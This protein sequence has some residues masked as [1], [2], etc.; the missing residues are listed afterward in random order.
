MKTVEVISIF[1]CMFLV[2]WTAGDG[3]PQW[4]PQGRFGKRFSNAEFISALR[5]APVEHEQTEPL[6][7]DDTGLSMDAGELE[8]LYNMLPA[9]S[10]KSKQTMLL[11]F[12]RAVSYSRTCSKTS[13][14]GVFKCF[15][16][17]WADRSLM[18]MHKD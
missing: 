7:L 14:L 16:K 9:N 15:R 4:R 12:P 11:P 1:L 5:T 13:F 3:A 18:A 17:R 6:Y 2:F 10:Q 8:T